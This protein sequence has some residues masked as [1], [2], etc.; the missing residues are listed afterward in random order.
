MNDMRLPAEWEPQQ[1]VVLAFPRR[2]GDWGPALADASRAMIAAAN[3]IHKVCPVLLIVSDEEHFA[4]YAEQYAGDVIEFATND[5]WTRDYGPITTVY[6]QRALVLNDFV[7]NGWGDKF[8]A[9]NDNGAPQRLWR[10]EFPES[11]YRAADV[12]LEGG[13]I[14]SDGAGTILTTTKCL[15]AP[16]RN[17]WQ[18]KA[19]AEAVFAD[20]FGAQRTLW[21]DHGELVGDDTDAHVDTLARF[22]DAETIAYVQ[23]TDEADEHYAELAKME[24]QLKT[25]RTAAGQPY[26]LLPLPLPPVITAA[27][28]G[29]RLPATYAN[30]LISNGTLFLPT[31]FDEAPDDHPGKATDRLALDRLTE[32][33]GYRVVTVNARPFIEQH[34]SLHCLTMQVPELS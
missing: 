28:D 7:F 32:Y 26:R 25:F 10:A 29:R 30:F 3:A 27:D 2:T 18:D 4:N 24:V 5:C 19:E 1:L 22:L 8:D 9:R 13:S 33:D 16:N 34:G 31:Y 17:D 15:F 14:E 20:Y 6:E 12:V 11:G 23:C 21:L